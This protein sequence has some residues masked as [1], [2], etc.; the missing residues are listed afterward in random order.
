M[1]FVSTHSIIFRLIRPVLN[2]GKVGGDFMDSTQT[3]VNVTRKRKF[4]LIT[5]L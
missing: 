5:R 4:S 1:I 3:R 2:I